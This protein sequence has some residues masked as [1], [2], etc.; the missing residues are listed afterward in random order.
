MERKVFFR[1]T[2][3][4]FVLILF[5]STPLAWAQK[6]RRQRISDSL[7][8][9]STR[10]E[11][12]WH[13][14]SDLQQRMQK[15]AVEEARRDYELYRQKMEERRT[16]PIPAEHQRIQDTLPTQRKR[17]ETIT[18]AMDDAAFKI[19]V[20]YMFLKGEQSFR[21]LNTTHGGNLSKLT[22]PIKGGMGF[23]DTEAKIAPRLFIGGRYA[24]SNFKRETCRDEDWNF[25]MGGLFIDYHLTEQ[26]STN[27]A[28]LWNANLYYRAFEWDKD[29]LGKDLTDLLR[30]DRL[31]IDAFAGYQYYQGKHTMVDPTT[32]HLIKIGG[33]WFKGNTPYYDGLNSWYE[34][35]YKGP[36][37]GFRIGG[38]VN[39]RLSSSISFSY[40][41]L[42][43]HAHAYW[44]LRD[45]DWNHQGQGLGSALNIDIEA[46][47][48][49]TAQWFLGAGF[50]Y[51][52]Q[53]HEKFLYSGSQ[54]AGVFTDLDIARDHNMHLYGLS[55]QLGY[56]W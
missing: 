2:L 42:R 10:Q 27:K 28:H 20:G 8:R 25:W 52:Q 51:M 12:Q 50:H 38:S 35:T 4:S 47:Y 39:E 11:T 45:F 19:K 48:Y 44:N 43:S 22:Y 15:E 7:D 18:K 1:Q 31:Y 16:A 41:W 14:E 17:Q 40:A 29:D 24:H 30:I 32:K 21:L 34:V 9:Y 49:L 26:D 55:L 54:P 36:R 3:A 37:A 23:V 53:K 56:Q 33:V 13:W 5:L 6:T 46:Q